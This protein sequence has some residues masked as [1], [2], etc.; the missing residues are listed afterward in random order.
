MSGME[1]AELRAAAQD[2]RRE[3]KSLM[4]QADRMDREASVKELP[5]VV[6]STDRG[7]LEVNQAQLRFIHGKAQ[8]AQG[9]T[10]VGVERYG[11]DLIVQYGDERD[12]INDLAEVVKHEGFD[13]FEN[14][15]KTL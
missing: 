1:A 13:P 7:R 15:W 4:T 6:F 9:I 2:A 5:T 8:E 3:A 10:R 12:F 11:L 14:D